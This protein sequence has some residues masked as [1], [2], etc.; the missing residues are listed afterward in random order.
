MKDYTWGIT[1]SV[2]SAGEQMEAAQ[3]LA[4][5]WHVAYVPRGRQNLIDLR[6]AHDLDYLVTLDRKM[7]VCVE[8]PIALHWHPSMAIPRLRQLARGGTDTFLRAA[9]LAPGDKVIDCTLGF[10]ADALLAALA[11]GD[12]GVVLGIEA[13]PIIALL[14]EYGLRVEAASFASGNK[15]MDAISSR[16]TVHAGESLAFL[17][18]QADASW[19]LVYF[20]PMFRAVN[21][22]ASDMGSIRPLACDLPVDA[23]LLAEAF[24]VCRKRVVLKERWFSPLFERL[25]ADHVVRTKYGPVAFGIWEK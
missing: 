6:I 19:E 7:R 20:D 11:V 25:G 18:T 14:T 17:R 24:R 12:G 23:D 22:R 8:E 16:I 13:S 21:P 10:G 4:Q 5:R 1:T 15:P 2:N 3:E 9:D